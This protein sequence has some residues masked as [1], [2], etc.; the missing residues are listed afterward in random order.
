M[1]ASLNYKRISE[2]VERAKGQIDHF[3]VG[4][5]AFFDGNPYAIGLKQDPDGGNGEYYVSRIDPVPDALA[6]T[7]ADVVQNLRAA[8]DNLATQIVENAGTTHKG[9][10][11]FPIAM[12][13][14]EYEGTRRGCIKG[15]R[16]EIIDTFDAAEP[17]KGG[18]GHGLWQL[19]KLSNLD[20]HV[21]PLSAGGFFGSVD[22]AVEIEH[23]IRQVPGFEN[24]RLPALFLR[25]AEKLLPLKQGDVLYRGPAD[26]EVAEKRRFSLDVGIVAP[27]ILATE[28]AAATLR[29]LAGLVG[30]TL[31]QFRRFF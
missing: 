27:E 20:K 21:L 14:R 8:L 24:A 28:P 3:E 12:S 6:G 25:P 7:A 1:Q 17:Y 10:I 9:S 26:P 31:L 4:L 16:Q 22:V 11:Y 30:D 29:R 5:R 15:V 19:Q 23:H 13:A 2:R 18:K